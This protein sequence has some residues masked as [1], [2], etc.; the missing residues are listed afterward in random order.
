MVSGWKRGLLCR[1]LSQYGPAAEV[2]RKTE[3]EILCDFTNEA[4]E[5]ELANEQLGRVTPDFAE[6]NSSGL[7]ATGSLDISRRR[8]GLTSSGGWT[9][10]C[11]RGVLPA[12]EGLVSSRIAFQCVQIN[13]PPVELRYRPREKGGEWSR[14]A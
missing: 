5:G 7:E 9:A 8:R 12:I 3:L 13:L 4:L 1:E 11:L 6:S 14:M 10:S 2:T